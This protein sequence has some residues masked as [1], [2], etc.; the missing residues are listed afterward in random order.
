MVVPWYV[1]NCSLEFREV[2]E[3]GMAEPCFKKKDSNPPVCG[4][5]N[6]PLVERQLPDELIAA[7]YKAFTFF[8][9][10]VS[11]AALKD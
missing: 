3:T 8:V 4:V 6:L 11:E 1:S 7:E 9:C 2:G 10:P 5:H